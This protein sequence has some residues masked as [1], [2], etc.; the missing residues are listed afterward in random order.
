MLEKEGKAKFDSGKDT[1]GPLTIA[2]VVTVQIGEKKNEKGG[3][4]NSKMAVFGDSDFANNSYLNILGNRDLFL[5][6]LNWLAEEEGLISIR[7]RDTDYNPVIL[8]RAMGKVIF[9]VPVV[10]IPAMILVSGIVVL[11][12][13]RWKK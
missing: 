4:K 1:R 9:F 10:I 2:A 11:S 7:P 3:G 12:V 13:K 8:S 5:N 6:T